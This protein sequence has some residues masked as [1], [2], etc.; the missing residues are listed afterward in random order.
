VLTTSKDVLEAVAHGTGPS[1]LL[2]S[3]GCSGWSAGQLEQEIARN[4]WLTV[5]ADPHIVFD[6]PIA[7]RFDAAMRLLGIDPMMF[8]GEAGHA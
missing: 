7:D 5:R 2:V 6:L 3:L 4:G 8:T 1:R